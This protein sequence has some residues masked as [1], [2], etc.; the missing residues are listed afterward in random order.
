MREEWSSGQFQE[1]WVYSENDEQMMS[2]LIN[3]EI[4]WL[5]YLREEGDS[6]FSSRNSDYTGDENAV[7]EFSF[8]NGEIS[9]YPLSWCLPVEEIDKALLYFEENYKPPMF[10]TWHKD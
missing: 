4:G 2:A 8:S 3:G 5:M 6:G 9:E 1:I 7:A 10:I